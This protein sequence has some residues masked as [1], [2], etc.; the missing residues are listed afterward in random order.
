MISIIIPNYNNER[1]VGKCIRSILNQTYTDVEIIAV[2]DDSSDNSLQ[3]LRKYEAEDKRVRVI[4]L[5]KNGGVE[6]AR[7]AG[8]KEAKGDFI[9]FVDSDDYLPKK[10]IELLFKKQNATDADV[11]EGGFARVFD[12]FGIKKKFTPPTEQI[13]CQPE[14]FDKY[15]IS[16]FGVNILNVSL[17]G[18]LYRRNLFSDFEAIKPLG[19]GM[20]E[21]LMLNMRIFPNIK[22]YAIISD[23]V[24]YYRW[25]GIT[26]GFNRHLYPSIK[27]EYYIKLKTIE[28]YDYKKA[29]RFTKIEMCNVFNTQ[30]EQLVGYNKTLNEIQKFFND[31]VESGFVDQITDGITCRGGYFPYLK[32]PDFNGYI[33][34]LKCEKHKKMKKSLLI[35]L[36]RIIFKVIS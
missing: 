4:A 3:V 36:L 24:Y 9:C 26:S 28:R 35:R 25:G 12:S 16:F 20:G 1:L 14:L 2:D 27:A 15:F 23:C 6:K 21:D 33:D 13:I 5:E 30:M 34:Y 22:K 11:V 31:E 10:A 7:L 29:L 8:I 19:L 18:K 32:Q 17:C